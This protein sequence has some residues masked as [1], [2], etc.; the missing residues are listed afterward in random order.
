MALNLIYKASADS[1]RAIDFHKKCDEA[2]STIV[3]IET[4]KGKRFGGYTS[5]SWKGNCKEKIDEDAFIFS[6]DKMKTY[7]I[8]PGKKAIG[9]Y[10]KFGPVFLGCQIKINDNA[11]KRGGTTFKKGINYKTKADFELLIYRK[12]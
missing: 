11:F 6:L 1:D 4:D 8:I 2:K 9:C 7:D 12:I 10:P 3:L 5:V